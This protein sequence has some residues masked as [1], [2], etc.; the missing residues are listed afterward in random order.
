MNVDEGFAGTDLKVIL[1][2]DSKTKEEGTLYVDDDS[3]T[4]VNVINHAY[5]FGL[6]TLSNMPSRCLS[7][8][9]DNEIL[10]T[11]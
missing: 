10:E 11:I 9:K 2:V 6:T 7:L 1:N 5:C 8:D 4:L 3:V